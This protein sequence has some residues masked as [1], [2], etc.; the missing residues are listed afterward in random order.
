MYCFIQSQWIRSSSTVIFLFFRNRK[1]FPKKYYYNLYY[2]LYYTVFPSES[3]VI[4]KGLVHLSI[5]RRLIVKW[6]VHKDDP[7]LICEFGFAGASSAW[8]KRR[9]RRLQREIYRVS[10]YY[11]EI[12]I[13]MYKHKHIHVQM[14]NCAHVYERINKAKMAWCLNLQGTH[15]QT[16]KNKNIYWLNPPLV[17]FLFLCAA[18]WL[19]V[20]F[21]VYASCRYK[22][23]K[24]PKDEAV[25]GK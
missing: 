20:Y 7:C 6:N 13:H 22:A 24:Q 12:S 10:S 3:T 11:P 8:N 15:L 21:E 25:M 4:I 1:E 14:K 18:C 19:C 23:M 5:N 2:I 17:V 16:Y 9:L